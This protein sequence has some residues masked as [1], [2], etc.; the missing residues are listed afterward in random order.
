MILGRWAIP[1]TVLACSVCVRTGRDYELK[2]SPLYGGT[3]SYGPRQFP[4][5][6]IQTE[7]PG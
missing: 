4:T 3:Q 1:R 7:I 2:A 5:E 6:I